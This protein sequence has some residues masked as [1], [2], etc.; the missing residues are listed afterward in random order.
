MDVS[1]LG[2]FKKTYH[3]NDFWMDIEHDFIFFAGEEHISSTRL[4]LNSVQVKY[5]DLFYSKKA[6]VSNEIFAKIG[7][8]IQHIISKTVLKN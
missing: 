3:Y 5:F 1:A 8:K 6:A 7:D 2:N 4:L